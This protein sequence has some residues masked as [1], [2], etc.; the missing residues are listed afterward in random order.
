MGQYDYF[1][2]IANNQSLDPSVRRR[3]M[4]AAGRA[5]GMNTTQAAQQADAFRA[6]IPVDT[7]KNQAIQDAFLYNYLGGAQGVNK[8]LAN[9]GNSAPDIMG[10]QGLQPGTNT[11]AQLNDRVTAANGGTQ[12][13]GV[14]YATGQG[15]SIGSIPVQELVQFGGFPQQQSGGLL[16]NPQPPQAGL[17]AYG[18]QTRPWMTDGAEAATS[19]MN[20]YLASQTNPQPMQAP[21]VLQSFDNWRNGVLAKPELSVDAQKI[22]DEYL[23]QEIAKLGGGSNQP[24][25][26]NMPGSFDG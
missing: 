6:Q 25:I 20:S 22:A 10:V 23:R 12:P 26:G 17:L 11:V 9:P 8:T 1:M 2:G 15:S 24:G 4:L 21:A 13:Q 16:G 7:A 18:P 19:Q 14:A 3:A 5:D